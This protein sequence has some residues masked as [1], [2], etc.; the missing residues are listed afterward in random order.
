MTKT[1]R[2]AV[3]GAAGQVA[4]AMT[5]DPS[6][7]VSVPEV[8]APTSSS[9]RNHKG[10]RSAPEPGMPLTTTRPPART[11]RSDR[12]RPPRDP[13]HSIATSAP[14]GRKSCPRSGVSFT[15]LRPAG[16]PSPRARA[17]ARRRRPRA[18][19]RCFGASGDD[20]LSR[21]R[22]QPHGDQGEDP[23]GPGADDR[24]R[25]APARSARG[26]RRDRAR[27][28]L[29]QHGGLVRGR[30]GD[31]VELRAMR[32]EL[33]A[34][35]AARLGAVAGLQ[36]G[37]RCPTVTRSQRPTSPAAQFGQSGSSPRASQPSTD[38]ST[39]R[40]P[41]GMSSTAS[42]S[43][44]TTSW[45]GTNGVDTERREVE[46][47]PARQRRQVAP[48]R[49]R[50]ERLHARPALSA[51]RGHGILSVPAAARAARRSSREL[52]RRP[53]GPDVPGALPEILQRKGRHG[54]RPGGHGLC[55]PCGRLCIST[56]W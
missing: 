24:R 35:A 1:V 48:R 9:S 37:F 54:S 8:Y 45:P 50:Q 30:V 11:V 41:T 20:A 34:P 25:S 29:D 46:R 17:A 26:A 14:P 6:G 32:D 23:D 27:E 31:R 15:A 5:R 52:S 2:V 39:T 3:T 53:Y 49:P 12:S 7:I 22:Q 51:L 21:L 43:S 19:A 40:P 18:A 16:R 36:P 42:R 38:E 44:P 4:Y 13:T 28:R 56:G 10:V 33:P 47:R 55:L